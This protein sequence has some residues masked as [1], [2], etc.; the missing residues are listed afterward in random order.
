MDQKKPNRP[1]PES[2]HAVRAIEAVT[3]ET[4]K[5]DSIIE[6]KCQISEGPHKGQQYKAT[7]WMNN[8]ESEEKSKA[9]LK[10]LGARPTGE[11]TIGFDPENSCDGKFVAQ[12][13]KDKNPKLD[14]N[15]FPYVELK[16][17][18]IPRGA[19]LRPVGGEKAAKVMGKLF[20]DAAPTT[21]SEPPTV[22]DDDVPF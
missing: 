12:L 17:L 9:I 18:N 20:G 15:G 1:E 14:G 21:T 16:W 19:K 2:T 7:L 8:T 10:H 11:T 22:S 13:D 5:G 6:V 3:S 4:Q